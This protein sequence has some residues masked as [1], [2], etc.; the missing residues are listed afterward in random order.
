MV[1]HWVADTSYQS[2]HRRPFSAS[3]RRQSQTAAGQKIYGPINSRAIRSTRKA[4]E[5]IG[6]LIDSSA[7]GYFVAD[8]VRAAAKEA[9]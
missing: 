6:R 7:D 2:G 9:I 4:N 8:T 3:A 1:G 5:I